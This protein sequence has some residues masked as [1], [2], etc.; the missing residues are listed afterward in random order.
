[1]NPYIWLYESET[2]LGFMSS[3]REGSRWRGFK[4]LV[5]AECLGVI[6]QSV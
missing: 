3:S 1:M 5:G 6:S 2:L 4:G